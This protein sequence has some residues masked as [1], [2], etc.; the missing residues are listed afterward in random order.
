[1]IKPYFKLVAVLFF[2]VLS[3][4]CGKFDP[5]DDGR[6][7][8]SVLGNIDIGLGGSWKLKWSQWEI[9]YGNR[10]FIDRASLSFLDQKVPAFGYEIG[11][12]P[13]DLPCSLTASGTTRV[14]TVAN[15]T[16]DGTAIPVFANIYK[17]Y[18]LV[19]NGQ[20]G[21]TVTVNICV[22]TGSA[23]GPYQGYSEALSIER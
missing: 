11:A 7:N 22:A 3:V 20:V 15:S 6:N 4:Q 23:E 18:F 10:L 19:P 13:D 17:I 2:T 1:M 8:F 9:V 21:Q 12:P 14:I 5:T 16:P